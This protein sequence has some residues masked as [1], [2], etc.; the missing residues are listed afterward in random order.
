MPHLANGQ[1][2]AFARRARAFSLLELLVVIA[3]SAIV[4]AI[5]LPSLSSA[6]ESAHIAVCLSN[7]RE[8]GQTSAAYIEDAGLPTEP[9]HLGFDYSG[10]AIEKVSEYVYGGFQAELDHPVL[11]DKLD[12]QKIH[13]NERPYNKYI[14]PGI[15]N[16]PVDT[17]ICPSDR[18]TATTKIEA[19]CSQPVVNNTPSW[20]I[21]GNSY[22]LNWNW[23]DAP[24]W[25]SKLAYYT[26]IWDMSAAGREML[27]LKVG[28]SASKFVLFMENPMNAYMQDA[29]PPSGSHGT[30]CQTQLG[31]G[32]HKQVSR[33]SVGFFDGHAAHR[34]IDTRYSSGPG[35]ETWP[36]PYTLSG[37]NP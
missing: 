1:H 27:R 11:G 25:N 17:Y 24:P 16:G 5:A 35:Y 9:W 20:M 34:F 8:L 4:I 23:L 13:T 21:N 22:S 32:W 37:F 7:I 19:P 28:G 2:A 36:E 15:C 12:T 14:A 10:G 33:Y 6:R 26:K 30:S 18:F 3:I 29:K 31:V